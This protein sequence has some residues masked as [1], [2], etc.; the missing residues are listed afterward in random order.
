MMQ[1]FKKNSH[2]QGLPGS[3]STCCGWQVVGELDSFIVFS[4]V[5]LT[6]HCLQGQRQ[7][8]KTCRLWHAWLSDCLWSSKWTKWL[9]NISFPGWDPASSHKQ[10]ACSVIVLTTCS[11]ATAQL[12]NQTLVQKPALKKNPKQPKQPPGRP[13]GG[14]ES[15]TQRRGVSGPNRADLSVNC[16]VILISFRNLI[17]I[18]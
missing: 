3:T 5:F 16:P 7:K 15:A 4:P 17:K 2:Y 18:L 8:E 1:T 14:R 13:P 6:S 12:S 10:K 11:Q 9:L